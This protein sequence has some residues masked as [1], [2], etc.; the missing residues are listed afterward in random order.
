MG[1]DSASRAKYRIPFRPNPKYYM[2]D[3]ILPMTSKTFL[4]RWRL[5]MQYNA[6]HPVLLALGVTLH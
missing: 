4:K 2:P 3:M 6:K 1:Y 5:A